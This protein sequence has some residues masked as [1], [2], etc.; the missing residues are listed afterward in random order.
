MD[1]FEI[2]RDHA[3]FAER[4]TVRNRPDAERLLLLFGEPVRDAVLRW[5]NPA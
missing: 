2:D 1:P 3:G 4:V 5:A